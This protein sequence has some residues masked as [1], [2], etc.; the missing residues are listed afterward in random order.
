MKKLEKLEKFKLESNG[1]LVGIKGGV[2]N[3]ESGGISSGGCTGNG[4]DCM[5]F[6]LDDS[7]APVRHWVTYQQVVC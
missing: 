6:A 2:S 3:G 4:G 1:K 7:G 5:W